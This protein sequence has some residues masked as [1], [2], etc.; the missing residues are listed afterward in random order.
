MRGLYMSGYTERVLRD[1]AEAAVG[2]CDP[3][4]DM[5]GSRDYKLDLVRA[6][7]PRVVRQALR[8]AAGDGAA[9]AF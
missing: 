5:R 7:V 9:G 2:A 8:R 4:S 1:A 3:D 6:L